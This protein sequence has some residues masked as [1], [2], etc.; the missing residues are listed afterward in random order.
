MKAFLATVGSDNESEYSLVNDPLTRLE[1]SFVRKEAVAEFYEQRR[2][3]HDHPNTVEAFL[4]T[5]EDLREQDEPVLQ[6]LK[7]DPYF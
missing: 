5:G 7:K 1:E 4:G 2:A 3:T 6:E